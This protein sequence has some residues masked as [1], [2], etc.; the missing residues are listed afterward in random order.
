MTPKR[1]SGD[2]LF[3]GSRVVVI[4][5]VCGA[6]LTIAAFAGKINNYY[7][8]KEIKPMIEGC[9][10]KY[11]GPMQADLRVLVLFQD[12]IA[13]EDST[14]KQKWNNAI[15]RVNKLFPEYA[16]EE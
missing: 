4:G 10:K 8:E 14:A 12:D 6:L 9:V 13:Q 16:V 3:N 7:K 5:T 1:R 11:T 15:R 2:K